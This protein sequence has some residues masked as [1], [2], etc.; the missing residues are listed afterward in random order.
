MSPTLPRGITGTVLRYGFAAVISTLTIGFAILVSHQ[1]SERILLALLL[2]PIVIS[3]FFWGFGPGMLATVLDGVLSAYFLFEPRFSLTIDSPIDMAYLVEVVGSGA[4]VSFVLKLRRDDVIGADPHFDA[5]LRSARTKLWSSAVLI[6]LVLAFMTIEV[7]GQIRWAQSRDARVNRANEVM[8]SIGQVQLLL[9]KAIA[10]QRGYLLT[11]EQ[12][13]LEPYVSATQGVTQQMEVLR[14]LLTDDPAQAARLQ[15][16]E[17]SITSR[18]AMLKETVARRDASGQAAAVD[19]M[20]ARQVGFQDETI[21]RRTHEMGEI[22]RQFATGRERESQQAAGVSLLIASLGS[23]LTL[24]AAA[25]ALW[26]IARDFAGS[27]R[28]SASLRQLT[29]E[30]E[31]RVRERTRELEENSRQLSASREMYAVTLGSIGDAVVSTDEQGKITWMNVE[32]ESLTGWNAAD[33]LGRPVDSVIRIVSEITGLSMETPVANVLQTGQKQQLANHA[34]LIARD[35]RR[36]PVADSGAPIRD[37]AGNLLGTVMVLRDASRDRERESILQEKLALQDQLMQVAESVP[38]ALCTVTRQRDG[39]LRFDYVS[40]AIEGLFGVRRE[41]LLRDGSILYQLMD[42][43]EAS[44]VREITA[45]SA[46]EL[47]VWAAEFRINH[48]R[49]GQ[50]WIEGRAVPRRLP[51]G[52]TQWHGYMTDVTERRRA[53]DRV[54]E[55]EARLSA[56]IHSALSGVVSVDDHSNIIL[57]NPA[58]EH[59]FGCDAEHALGSPLDRFIPER[60]RLVHRDQ[61]RMFGQSPITGKRMGRREAT[62]GV[63]ENGELFP[64]EASISHA[65]VAGKRLFTAIL[66]DMTE[67]QRAEADLRQQASLLDLAPV[68]VRDMQDRIVQWS[69]GAQAIYGFSGNEAI[70]RVCHKLLN[71]EFPVPLA[72]IQR[73]LAANGAWEGELRHRSRAGQT[74]Y[75]ASKW[76]LYRDAQGA[77]IRVL[78]VDADITLE[79][80]TQELHLRSQKLESLGTLAGGIAHDFNNIILSINGNADLALSSLTR[81]APGREQVAEI[82]KA[83]T[84][85]SELVRRILA[86]SRPQEEQK[87]TTQLQPVIDEALKLMRAT[88]PAR[89]QIKTQFEPGLAHVNVNTGQVHQIV[90]NLVTNA[91]HAIGDRNGLIECRLDHAHVGERDTD[92]LK[93]APGRYVRLRITDS[94]C[95]M[96]ADTLALIFDPFFTT[97]RVGEGTGLGLSVV[98][99][100]ITSYQGG[101]TVS[102][103]PGK[104]STFSLFFPA[105]E[106]ATSEEAH[107][108]A[109]RPGVLKRNVRLLYIDD[110]QS[111][112]VLVTQLLKRQGYQVEGYSEA[113]R[114]LDELARRPRD[115][116][117]M[118]TDLSMPGTSGFEVTEA[119]RAIRPDLPVVV[120]SGYL[121]EEDEETARR[122][123]VQATILKSVDVTV[124]LETIVSSVSEAMSDS[125][126]LFS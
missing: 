23:L 81:D 26:F 20:K 17:E 79:R 31:G 92:G 47:S 33:A 98:H 93:L 97:K 82:V 12:G 36:T 40:A 117:A 59:M 56:I 87:T 114:A 15:S 94:G 5:D 116:D 88:V 58:A 34:C 95:G 52:S 46:A 80:R 63:R 106:L 37:S 125:T 32:A 42:D 2:G 43:A 76:V 14:R 41:V 62:Y 91:A 39:V 6:A 64:I 112:V 120:M 69:Q 96:P 85:A 7:F 54:E 123:N 107:V 104:G 61:M 57:F 103:Q 77:P 72:E 113:R 49:H 1:V 115:F 67:Q 108:P 55:G 66:R 68:V 74:V 101:I 60:F 22:E 89:I 75:V 73:V 83:G 10:N 126:R 35:G 84:R 111:L 27:Q 30:L 13:Y 109:S 21:R 28:N 105:C 25:A 53:A 121:R 48:P 102:S 38:G 51:D 122:L 45:R 18:L 86:F 8:A 11:G 78:E 70:G 29:A 119:A 100:I 44:R 16:L 50:V 65:Q 19:L 118:I 24:A 124:L 99:G 4:F 110:E 71:T 90:V 3:A 9:E